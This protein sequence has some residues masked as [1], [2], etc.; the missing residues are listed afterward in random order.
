MGDSVGE[1]DRCPRVS[2][3][4][5]CGSGCR[6]SE[7]CTAKHQLCGYGASTPGRC[8]RGGYWLL[9]RPGPTPGEISLRAFHRGFSSNQA[10][11]PGPP[12]EPKHA[13]GPPRGGVG[14]D[15]LQLQPQ[16]R[17]RLAHS[18]AMQRPPPHGCPGRARGTAR[19]I[20]NLGTWMRGPGRFPLF[21]ICL[22]GA[23]E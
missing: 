11:Q 18:R 9:E 14:A 3:E 22:L 8:S 21:S 13:A 2:K 16:S 12:L 1:S 20:N 15:S 10:S 19:A 23:C 17:T 6:R 7:L 4:Q 5:V